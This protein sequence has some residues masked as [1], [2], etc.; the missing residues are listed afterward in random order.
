MLYYVNK[1]VALYKGDCL[2]IMPQLDIKF[3][4]CITDPPYQTTALEWDFVIPFEPMWK[5]L[6]RLVGGA[7]V[8]FSSQPFTTDLIQSNRKNFKYQM[9]WKK[10]VPTGMSLAKFRPMKYH[11]EVLVFSKKTDSTYNPIMKERVGKG[12][13]CYNYNHY[14]GENNHLKQ[15][16]KILKK[17]DPDFVQPSTVLEFDVVPNRNGKFHPTQKPVELIEYLIKTYTN[18]NDIVLDFTAGSG[19]TGVACMNTNRRCILIEKEEKYC[20]VIVNR[21]KELENEKS[22]MLF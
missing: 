18:E 21:L 17:Y 16:K 13:E 19:T 2:D 6:D 20:E 5:E 7:V 12:K 14:C 8:L 10:N 3:D 9:I 22:Q 11:E 1:S 15:M 4:A